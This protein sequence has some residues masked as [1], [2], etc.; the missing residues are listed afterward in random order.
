MKSLY[1]LSTGE[2]SNL[3]FIV[4]ILG[5]PAIYLGGNALFK[6]AI[7]GRLPLSRLAGLAML[8]SLL[9]VASALSSLTLGAATS[10]IL[11]IVAAWEWN[12]LRRKPAS[13][14]SSC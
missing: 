13:L 10:L 7:C 1:N 14:R 9:P 12:S 8:L 11:A 4:V 2:A 3:C 5:G 6:R